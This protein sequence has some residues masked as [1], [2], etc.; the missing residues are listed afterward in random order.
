[1]THWLEQFFQRRT[2]GGLILRDG[3]ACHHQT[4][5]G[6]YVY[7]DRFTVMDSFHMIETMIAK[8][9]VVCESQ[10]DRPHKLDTFELTLLANRDNAVYTIYG[11]VF[12]DIKL[13]EVNIEQDNNMVY[14]KLKEVTTGD[15]E[16]IKVSL[17]R[18]YVAAG[19]TS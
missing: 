16:R 18:N 4:S 10:K 5:Q 7:P 2:D 12:T 9:T 8:Y 11:R 6:L 1:M 14:L 13:V 17:I 15:S 19:G 3:A